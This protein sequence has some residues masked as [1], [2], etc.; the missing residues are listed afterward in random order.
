MKHFI[1]HFRRYGRDWM[2]VEPATLDGPQGRIQVA[3]GT[4]LI[5]G[6]AFMNV[7]LAQLLEEEHTREGAR[8]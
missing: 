3:S 5:L 8:N 6:T 1:Q 4:I 2:C 7:D